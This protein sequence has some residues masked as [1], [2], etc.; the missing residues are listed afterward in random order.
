MESRS[1]ESSS[2]NLCRTS[3][4]ARSL[5]ATG[6]RLDRCLFAATMVDVRS[7]NVRGGFKQKVDAPREC[8]HYVRGELVQESATMVGVR[9]ANARGGS[10]GMHRAIFLVPPLRS[11]S[12]RPPW[13][14]P[15]RFVH[16][17]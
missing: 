13:Q 7:A 2:P 5:A 17:L 12:E 4:P 16:K 8:R 3:S 15:H 14:A 6:S 9:S 10:I 1:W 11:R